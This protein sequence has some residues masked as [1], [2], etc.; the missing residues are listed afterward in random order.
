MTDE[1][2][3]AM[4]RAWEEW[5][6]GVGAE[7]MPQP[8]SSFKAGFNAG[9]VA[10]SALVGI[11]A[12]KIRIDSTEWPAIRAAIDRMIGDCRPLHPTDQ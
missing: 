10:A 5:H 2:N 6:F 9:I 3:A 12:G 1:Q 4:Q 11:G 7:I 8:N